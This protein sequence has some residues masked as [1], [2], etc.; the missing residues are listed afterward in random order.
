MPNITL[1]LP[2]DVYEI[3]KKHR[4][5]RWSE[6]ARRAIENYA[7]KLVLLDALTSGSTLTEE[8]ILEIDEKIKEGIYRHYLEKKNETGN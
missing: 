4:E 6:I 1:S 3:V 7:R 2:D 8:D 5:I